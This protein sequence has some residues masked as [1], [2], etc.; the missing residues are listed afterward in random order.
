MTPTLVGLEVDAIDLDEEVRDVSRVFFKA[1]GALLLDA[2]IIIT[3]SFEL[4]E[5]GLHGFQ[6]GVGGAEGDLLGGKGVLV[7]A[8][9][10]LEAELGVVGL[11]DSHL[12]NFLSK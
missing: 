10:A 6:G 2:I 9:H 11:V 12:H 8:L 7:V 3:L 1:I 5:T 4:C